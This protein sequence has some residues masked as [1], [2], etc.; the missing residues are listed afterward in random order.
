MTSHSDREI[1]KTAKVGITRRLR[2]VWH[3]IRATMRVL[4][5]VGARLDALEAGWRQN[6][7]ALLNAISSVGAFGHE[8]ARTQREMRALND[9]FGPICERIEFVR[10][11]T[12]Y[13][14]K[15]GGPGAGGSQRT[16]EPRV[17]APEKLSTAQPDGLKL[18]L[19]CGHVPLVGY[20]NVDRRDLP[21]VDIIA[22]AGNIPVAP[23]SVQEI[24][25]FHL[26]E[27][28]SEEELRRRLLPYWRTLLVPGGRFR[29]V[30][31]D[32]EAMLASMASKAYPFEEFR[33]VVFGAQDYD[34]DFHHNLFTPDSLRRLIEE[35]GFRDV[36][37][38]IKGRRN[39]KCFE[40]EITG[41]RS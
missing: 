14:M 34:G 35:A 26:L 9:R 30:V 7:P 29:A 32:G 38:P 5:T 4:P 10:R 20:V 28:F 41:L 12:L 6:I 11:E 2:G 31:P 21:G 15:Y 13:E 40:F 39:G 27:H 23:D 24:A 37:V 8:L 18:N 33:E 1:T 3:R 19:G 22:D 25:S 17:L 36:N 16:I